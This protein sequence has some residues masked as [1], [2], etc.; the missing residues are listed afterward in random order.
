[1]FQAVVGLGVASHQT[2][3]AQAPLPADQSTLIF[4]SGPQ[5]FIA[6]VAGVVMAFAFQFV[7]TN[8]GIAA[9]L[10][11]GINPVDT[12]AKNWGSAIRRIESKV[13]IWTLFIVNIALFTACFLSVKLTLIQDA[14]L[15][16][17]VSVVIWSVYFLLLLWAGSR[18][19]GSLLG[20]VASTAGAG[21]QGVMA[22]V[23]TA[24]SGRAVN[25]QIVNTVEASVEAVTKELR[26][27]LAPDRLRGSIQDY[28]EK[29]QIPQPDLKGISSQVTNLLNLNPASL[30]STL[31]SSL[32]NLVQTATP[33]ELKSGKLRDA[34]LTALNDRLPQLLNT[35]QSDDQGQPQG[36][37]QPDQNQPDQNQP[38]QNQQQGSFR[39]QAIQQLVSPLIA[40]LVQ[41]VDL[42]ELDVEQISNQLNSLS[43]Q[44]PQQAKQAADAF[45]Q[46]RA[47]SIIRADIET[48][49]LNSPSWYLHSNSLDSG[50]REVLFDPNANPSLVRQQLEQLN[51]RY[52]V[53]VL[54]RREGL[55]PEQVNDVADQLELIRQEVLATV[56]EVEEQE[57]AQNLRQRAETY[58]SSAPKESLTS[59]QLQ[60]DVMAL[61]ADPT[62][63]YE[64]L[65]NRLVQ[66]DR[67]T[68][69]QMLLAGRQDLSQEETEQIL[70]ALEAARDRF[71][72]QSQE[73]WNQLQSQAGEFRGR[74]ESYLRETNPAEV[75]AEGIR[76][77]LDNLTNAYESGE[78]VIRAGLGEFDRNRLEQILAE[79][80]DLSQEQVHQFIDQVESVRD[81]I[82]HVPQSLTGQ[83][84]EQY[85][86]L[87][88]R[89]A[90]YL[91]NTNQ[92]E[93]NPEGIRRDLQK[94][95]DDPQA[96]IAAWRDRLSQVD[97]DTLVKLLSQRGDLNEQQ[98]NQLVDQ[99]QQTIRDLVRAP[100][101]FTTRTRDRLQDIQ[102]NFSDYLRNTNREELN[103]EGIQRDLKRLFQHPRAGI[104]QLGERLS[105]VNR[106]TVVALLSQREDISEEEANQI[107]DQ[108]ESTR[109]R[110][111]QQAQN[112][113]HQVQSAVNSLFERLRGALNSLEQS[114]LNYENIKRDMQQ[115]FEDPEA[116]FEALRDRLSQFD[117]QTLVSILSSRTD[118]SEEQAN[119]IV[120]QIES[121]R[122]TVLHQAE[123]LQEEAEKRISKL[124]HQ[125]KEQAEE[126]QKT[127][128]TAAWWL[129][130]TAV[131]SVAAAVAAGMIAANGFNF[132]S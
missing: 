11:A 69:M 31:N 40:A 119:Q 33:N 37:N 129:F 54:Q 76:Q 25:A 13:G 115:L 14:E 118:L 27:E 89:I 95:L 97:R 6:L 22:T 58:L 132:I 46:P 3:I 71:L 35:G 117:R 29:L 62:A 102:Q 85:D 66:F 42:S 78:L 16:A 72:N 23:A 52:F 101:R 41:R 105:H 32:L 127:V 44:L 4:L 1:M 81:S 84:K 63:S 7:L 28:V 53:G 90:D 51:R 70:S 120:D 34:L 67:N 55:K 131:T 57:K 91:Q 98:V 113:Q 93:L 64:T 75:T 24:L 15:G 88:S 56:R 83:A 36:Q 17:I 82:L 110:L 47:F 2:W 107:A 92:E 74:V 109:T 26:S 30:Q 60:Q 21:L 94:L 126:A 114:G 111:I 65:G 87:L 8:F 103:P 19:V 108:V 48:Y 38:D 10:S 96:G 79:R 61:F 73:Q 5:F 59:E 43:Q 104:E 20:T 122:D 121:A 130:G 45:N 18:T 50:F 9:D 124:K 49:L 39:S 125:A 100:Q 80:Q 123:R 68:L 106:E 128:A 112:A 99:V 86:R 12:D 77:M 116:G